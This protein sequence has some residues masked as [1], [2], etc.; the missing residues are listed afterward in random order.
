MENNTEN[1]GKSKIFI[2]LL[3]GF[4]AFFIGTSIFLIL[5][6]Q[7]EQAAASGG[8]TNTTTDQGAVNTIKQDT[9]TFPSN[10]KEE[11]EYSLTLKTEAEQ[12]SV[13]TVINVDIYANSNLKNVVGYDFVLKYDPLT[14]DYMK[15]EPILP[16]F[17]IYHYKKDNYLTFTSTRDLQSSP[18][19]FN[20]VKIASIF[21]EAKKAG[22]SSFSLEPS[23]DKSK[24]DF[25]TDSTE[26]LIPALNEF[27]IDVK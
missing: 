19:P 27:S 3:V 16:D 4:F 21:F 11:S 8:N 5:N 22:N 12:V 20:D 15:I 17:R 10:E 18:A 7:K 6:K 23:Y 26:V 25:I 9:L 1:T 13:G 14:F 2:Y 24:T